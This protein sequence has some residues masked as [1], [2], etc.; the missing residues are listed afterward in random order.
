MYIQDTRSRTPTPDGA[1][2]SSSSRRP[3]PTAPSGVL[4]A[5]LV[6][7]RTSHERLCVWKGDLQCIGNGK[8][9]EDHQGH[10]HAILMSGP[11]PQMPGDSPG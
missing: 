5:L 10:P 4:N 7:S 9:L 3:Q 2:R 8:K 6:A 1:P 11:V